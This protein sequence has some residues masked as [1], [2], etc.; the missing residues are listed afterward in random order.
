MTNLGNVIAPPRLAATGR[1]VNGRLLPIY[2]QMEA[3]VW[4]HPVGVYL[5]ALAFT[6]W[7]V[8]TTAL[9]LPTALVGVLNVVLEQP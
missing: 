1:D 6:L 5:P 3:S 2:F 4:F 9:R 7:E 8:S